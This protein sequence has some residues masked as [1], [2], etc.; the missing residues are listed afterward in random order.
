MGMEIPDAPPY[1][2]R[3]RVRVTWN[4]VTVLEGTVRKCAPAL[5]GA[6][7]VWQVEICDDWKPLEGTTFFGTVTGGGSRVG[8]S[9]AHCSD[10]PA[11]A[12]LKRKIKIAAALKAVL[13]DA[14]KH[15]ALAT[16]YVLD[17]DDRAWVWDTDIS[18]DK[19]ASLLRKL[20]SKRPGMVAWFD[21]SGAAP[22]L[23]IADGDRLEPVTLDR[24][25]DR[26]SKIQLTERLDL[27]PPAVGVIATSQWMPPPWPPWKSWGQ[28]TNR[29]P[30]CAAVIC[31]APVLLWG[32]CVLWRR[33]PPLTTSW[34]N[35]MPTRR[36]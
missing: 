22:V 23:H 25:R 11:G 7:Y 18:C 27:V 21:Y 28:S 16:E 30:G 1:Q 14:R 9:F 8:F 12:V 19:H 24:I 5:S 13:D 10:I 6:S 26:L 3:D 29:L 34:L 32:F 36:F 31:A 15:G 17:V 4:G 2:Y 33:M 20:L 35:W